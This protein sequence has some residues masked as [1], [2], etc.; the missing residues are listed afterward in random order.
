MGRLHFTLDYNFT[1]NML[2]VGIL[3]AAELPAMDLGGSSDPD[4]KL[5]LLPDKKKKFETKVL[6]KNLDPNFNETF[7]FKVPYTELGGRKLVMTVYDF[8]RFSK[9]DAIGAVKIPMSTADFSQSLELLQKA[10]KEE[11]G[12]NN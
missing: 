8:D 7:S 12:A 6:R 9:H 5:Y 3:Q 4:I 10:E 11:V 2:V 1:D